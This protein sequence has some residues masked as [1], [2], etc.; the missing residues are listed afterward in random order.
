MSRIFAII[1]IISMITN[2]AY[3]AGL[4]GGGKT[5]SAKELKEGL[6]E[7]AQTIQDIID[8]E[9]GRDNTCLDE[10][11]ARE[12]QLTKWLVWTPPLAVAG[13]PVSA[14]G[15]FAAGAGIA[16][17]VGAGGW[18][19]LGYGIGGGLIGFGASVLSFV[20]IEAVS[21]VRFYKNRKF[22]HLITESNANDL[23]GYNVNKY[24]RK[25]QSA[26]PKDEVDIELFT[27]ALRDLDNSGRLCDGSMLGNV[28]PQKL[29][30]MLA[31]KW[32]LFNA[33]HSEYAAGL[34]NAA[35]H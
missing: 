27:Q 6:N 33:L 25:Y 14:L 10:Y 5:I 4:Q 11:V 28:N 30:Y 13:V 22:I 35:K 12:A 9:I 32:E 18:A 34:I 19:A 8:E 16:N 21:G 23:E 31:G 7:S 3:A 24:L 1:F 15:G 29:K 26:F 17:L 20:S 2:T